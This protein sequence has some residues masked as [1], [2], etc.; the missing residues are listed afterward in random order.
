MRLAATESAA[1]L[2]VGRHL[3]RITALLERLGLLADATY[4]AHIGRPDQ[5]IRPLAELNRDEAPYFSMIL[6]GRGGPR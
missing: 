3:G 5:E 4:A 6:A 2:K 1:I